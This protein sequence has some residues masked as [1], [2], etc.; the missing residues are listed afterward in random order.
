MSRQK[1]RRTLEVTLELCHNII[2]IVVTKQRVEER[3]NVV[4]S[5]P[6]VAIKAG[7]SSMQNIE[8]LSRKTLQR[9]TWQGKRYAAT[10]F[11]MSRQ[12]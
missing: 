10:R 7:K 6:S 3:N 2:M 12:L 5:K 9:S 11:L 1:L 4:R 8:S